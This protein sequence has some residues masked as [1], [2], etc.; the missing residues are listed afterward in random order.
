MIPLG[1]LCLRQEELLTDALAEELEALA[2]LSSE[3]LIEQRYQRFRRL[4]E[5]VEPQR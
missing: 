3:Q 2:K 4:G 1:I 5:Y